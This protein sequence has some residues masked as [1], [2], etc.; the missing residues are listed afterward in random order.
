ML[1]CSGLEP[2]YADIQEQLATEDR[3]AYVLV[4]SEIAQ[5]VCSSTALI[6]EMVSEQMRREADGIIWDEEGEEDVDMEEDEVGNHHLCEEMQQADV[7]Q[8]IFITTWVMNEL[9]HT[10]HAGDMVWDAPCSGAIKVI[11]HI[12]SLFASRGDRDV[13]PDDDVANASQLPVHGGAL[14][15]T[16]QLR[17]D[18]VGH[19]R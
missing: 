5:Y 14:G 2:L 3:R 1:S 19:Q 9:C 12:S 17:S 8:T 13:A 7:G 4:T 6:F 10:R 16:Q 11:E 15:L 18:T